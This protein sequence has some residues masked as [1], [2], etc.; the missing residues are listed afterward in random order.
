MTLK[1]QSVLKIQG[2]N[3]SGKTTYLRILANLINFNKGFIKW[4]DNH[5]KYD[6]LKLEIKSNRFNFIS[7][8]KEINPYLTI[9]E[10]FLNQ[11][12]INGKHIKDIRKILIKFGLVDFANTKVK[13]LSSGQQQRVAIAKLVLINN[14]IWILDEPINFLD[15]RSTRLFENL[16][17]EHR[18]DFGITLIATHINL[19]IY[20]ATSIKFK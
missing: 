9:N 7:S 15:S 20:K 2:P 13:L 6:L 16:I 17:I 18:N 5:I 12:N 1:Q 10:N 8:N 14:P 19:N 3:G 11:I 4:K